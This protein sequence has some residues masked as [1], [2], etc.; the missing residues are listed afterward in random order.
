VSPNPST[1]LIKGMKIGYLLEFD[2]VQVKLWLFL[3]IHIYTLQ[4]F[5]ESS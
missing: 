4:K 1:A 5:T 2:E 3:M